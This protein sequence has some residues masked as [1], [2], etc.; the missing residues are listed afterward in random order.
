MTATVLDNC[1]SNSAKRVTAFLTN[2]SDRFQISCPRSITAS[3]KLRITL[4]L[5]PIAHSSG[6]AKPRTIAACTSYR[7]RMTLLKMSMIALSSAPN[8]FHAASA[9]WRALFTASIATTRIPAAPA[10]APNCP[11]MRPT[12]GPMRPRT[13]P[14]PPLSRLPSMPIAPPDAAP[15]PPPPPPPPVPPPPP[16]PLAPRISPSTSLFVMLS[17]MGTTISS[18]TSTRAILAFTSST[19]SVLRSAILLSHYGDFDLCLACVA[20]PGAAEHNRHLACFDGL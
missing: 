8:A 7:T 9:H 15:P 12:I 4:M 20:I 5:L 11:A 10:S 1:C 6:R 14:T 2:L 17:L 3:W 16:P 13:P 19:I 18:G